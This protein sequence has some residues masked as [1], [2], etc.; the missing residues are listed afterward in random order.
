MTKKLIRLEFDDAIDS[1]ASTVFQD[2]LNF[3]QNFYGDTGVYFIE[4]TYGWNHNAANNDFEGR[5]L[6]N[7]VQQ[8]E[9]HK[10]EPKDVAG[11][12]PTGTTQ[13][14]YMSRKYRY[15]FGPGNATQTVQ[16]QYRTDT[17]G[18]LSS[19]W[20]AKIEIYRYE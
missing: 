6:I 19:I 4:V 5:L 15:V 3:S 16:L 9:L 14:Y 7:G 12:D 13:R 11:V 17:G 20:E 2:K 8:G 10:Q 1:T 18:V